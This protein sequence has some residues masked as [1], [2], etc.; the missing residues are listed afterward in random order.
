MTG[1]AGGTWPG[2]YPLRRQ[3]RSNLVVH[4]SDQETLPESVAEAVT[5]SRSDRSR[6]Q[7]YSCSA[8]EGLLGV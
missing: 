1:N 7:E 3:R 2:K 5:R 6:Q 4:W 8:S